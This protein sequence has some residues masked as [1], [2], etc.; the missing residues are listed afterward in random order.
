MI[1]SNNYTLNYYFF[2]FYFKIRNVCSKYKKLLRTYNDTLI[3]IFNINNELTFLKTIKISYL[4]PTKLHIDSMDQ[5]YKYLYINVLILLKSN[6]IHKLFKYGI[7]ISSI[8]NLNI[9]IF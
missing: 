2:N 4:V 1:S 6:V 8:L 9:I 3:K 7:D 5:I